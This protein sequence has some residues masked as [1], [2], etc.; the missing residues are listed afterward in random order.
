MELLVVMDA[1]KRA[2]ARRINVIF[3]T[4]ATDGRI[5][6]TN[7]R[8]PLGAKVVADLLAVAGADRVI[9]IDLHC[10]PDPGFL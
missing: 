10:G 2:S 5:R 9:T 4:T 6:R 8:V 7:H 3:P 1:L